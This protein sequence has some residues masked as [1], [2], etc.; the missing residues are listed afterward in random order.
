MRARIHFLHKDPILNTNTILGLHLDI[1][2]TSVF[3]CIGLSAIGQD[4]GLSVPPSKN[5]HKSGVI[6]QAGPALFPAAEII[7]SYGDNHTTQGYPYPTVTLGAGYVVR[8]EGGRMFMGLIELVG[9]PFAFTFD[10][11]TLTDS[12]S[13]LALTPGTSQLASSIT[14]NRI[15]VGL[16]WEE[17]LLYSPRSNLHVLVGVGFDKIISSSAFELRQLAISESG[18]ITLFQLNVKYN[19]SVRY[20]GYFGL[21][22]SYRIG[23]KNSFVA[24]F[25]YRLT[26]GELYRAEYVVA[27][28]QSLRGGGMVVQAPSYLQ[29]SLGYVLWLGK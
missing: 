29:F 12:S 26:S 9:V 25:G 6:L 7:S 27:P 13:T 4:Q 11:G 10:P 15:C 14:T 2:I 8:Q 1:P 28:G 23:R 20:S 17:R 3:F 21:A 22:Y 18:S 5:D 16:N 19:S 24:N